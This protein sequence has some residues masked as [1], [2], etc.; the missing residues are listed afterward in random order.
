MIERF[1]RKGTEV[2]GV[3][4]TEGQLEVG[5]FLGNVEAISNRQ[6]ASLDQLKEDL[7]KKVQAKGGNCLDQFKYVQKGTVFSFSSTQWKAT[8]RIMKVNDQKTMML[9]RKLREI[10]VAI[11]STIASSGQIVIFVV[12]VLL[13]FVYGGSIR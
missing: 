3:F 13:A 10:S 11:F 5:E 6:N 4:F 9:M 8:G 7:A 2:S 12:L 1:G